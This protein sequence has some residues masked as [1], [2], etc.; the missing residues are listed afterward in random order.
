MPASMP[1][2]FT[3]SNICEFT[4]SF[5]VQV[6]ARAQLCVEEARVEAVVVTQE[7]KAMRSLVDA[8]VLSS[9]KIMVDF[10]QAKANDRTT[11]EE[12]SRQILHLRAHVA[13]VQVITAHNVSC[14][15]TNMPCSR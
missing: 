1:V 5:V 12:T 10:E 8:L 3:W 2:Q 9:Q 15:F 14:C 4:F 11:K 13:A 6:R 7:S